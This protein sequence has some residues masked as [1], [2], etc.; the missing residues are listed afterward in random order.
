VDYVLTFPKQLPR[1]P[2]LEQ[3]IAKLAMA[4]EQAGF[5]VEQ[6]IKLL[7]TGL[8]VATFSEPNYVAD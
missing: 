5:S 2:N 7:S 6:M 8:S 4:G 3:S 1:T